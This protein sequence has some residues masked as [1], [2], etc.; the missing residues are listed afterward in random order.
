MPI[1]GVPLLEHWI[2]S[3]VEAGIYDIFVNLHHHQDK[4][5]GFLSRPQLADKVH[6]VVENRLLG[7]AATIR[8]NCRFLRTGPCLVAH[9]DNWIDADLR[10]FIK[11]HQYRRPK[12]TVISMMTFETDTPESCGIVLT[13]HRGIV[14]S[15]EEKP[16]NA[17]SRVANGAVYIVEA[18]VVD[19]ISRY[20]EIADFSTQVIP[21]FLGR[22]AEWRNPGLHRDIGSL[23]RLRRAQTDSAVPRHAP[24]KD[25]WTRDFQSHSIHKALKPSTN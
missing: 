5:A 22:I 25:K 17:S 14:V 15:M 11:F 7:T 3:L 18:E 1:K 9:C 16:V 23:D 20:P 4:V 6:P 24:F 13:D 2:F 12:D 10:G 21:E 8:E 19:W